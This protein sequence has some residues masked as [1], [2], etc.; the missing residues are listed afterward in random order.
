MRPRQLTIAEFCAQPAA[1]LQAVETDRRM[2][3]LVRDGK[4]IAY[5]S[6]A[7]RP[8]GDSGTLADWEGTGAGFTLAPGCSLDDPAFT[9]EEWEEFPDSSER[10]KHRGGCPEGQADAHS[11]E[12][13]KA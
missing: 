4:V 2:I 10:C 12:N 5:V 7:P 3:E 13:L 1:A 11:P 8:K 9:L 6:P